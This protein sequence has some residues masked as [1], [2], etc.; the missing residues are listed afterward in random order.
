MFYGFRRCNE[1]EKWRN[2]LATVFTGYCGCDINVYIIRD[3]S[4]SKYAKFSE[5]VTVLTP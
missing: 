4:F 1:D 2:A 3:H 5:K